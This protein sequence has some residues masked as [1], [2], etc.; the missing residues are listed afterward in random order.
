MTLRNLLAAGLVTALFAAPAFAADS[1]TAKATTTPSKQQTKVRDARHCLRDTGTLLR[2]GHDQ[3]APVHGSTYDRA[4]IEST[5]GFST[6]DAI[7]QLD[8][9]SGINH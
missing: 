7:S 6:S 2:L 8:A 1:G 5:S 3:C 9:S 4:D